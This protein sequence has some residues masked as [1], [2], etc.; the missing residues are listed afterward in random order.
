MESEKYIELLNGQIEKLSN[1]EFE[2]SAWKSHTL[3]LV[4]RI[5]GKE[6][7]KVEQIS[8]LKTDFGSWSLRDTSGIKTAMD[9]VK[10]EAKEI[11]QA[12]I[13][14]LKIFGLPDNHIS[15]QNSMP[16]P[17][18][19]AILEDE[20]KGSQVRNLKNIL[21]D[22]EKDKDIAGAVKQFLESL[23]DEDVR[24]ILQRILTENKAQIL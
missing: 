8:N 16:I 21:T 22:S 17:G 11:L 18:L 15:K 23:E 3:A 7:M 4:S 14:E 5:F 13:D 24:F 1:R 9:I 10:D 2:L 12:A 19:K 6:D 20:L